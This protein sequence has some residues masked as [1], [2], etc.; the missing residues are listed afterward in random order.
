MRIGLAGVGH[1]GRRYLD[2]VKPSTILV[3][4]TFRAGDG[5]GG[6]WQTNSLNDFL[7]SCD[8][9]IVATPVETHANIIVAALWA[10]KRVLCEKPL[11]ASHEQYE[12]IL[13]ALKFRAHP[14]G[15][16]TVGYTHLWHPAFEALRAQCERTRPT[17]LR[18]AFG[19]ERGDLLDW[20]PHALSAIAALRPLQF[21]NVMVG[22]EHE[23]Y[24]YPGKRPRA[25]V[26]ALVG[27]DALGHYYA[28]DP[29]DPPPLTRMVNW[30]LSGQQDYRSEL[31]RRVEPAVLGLC[32]GA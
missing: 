8:H 14:P 18:V 11:C 7:D 1:Q 10:D 17:E 31:W 21:L 26:D 19:S 6:I 22:R 30:W 23:R 24:A 28:S 16:L 25:S 27:A 4:R 2:I 3:R 15:Q 20:A 12:K 13:D 9:V 32:G 5:F 29:S